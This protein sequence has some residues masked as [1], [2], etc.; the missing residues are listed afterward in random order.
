MGNEAKQD[1]TNHVNFNDQE[2]EYIHFVNNPNEYVPSSPLKQ[3]RKLSES[4]LNP[5]NITS[6]IYPEYK[7]NLLDNLIDN[8]KLN[9][10][11]IKLFLLMILYLTGEGFVMIGISLIIPVIGENWK[12]TEF[13]KGF[14]GGSVFLG[15]TFGAISAG[16]ISDSKGRKISF[17]IGNIISLGGALIGIILNYSFKWLA[18]SNFFIGIGIGI[19]IPSVFSLCSEITPSKVRSLI[20][21]WIWTC[22]SIGEISGCFIARHYEMHNYMNNNWKL[23]LIFRSFNVI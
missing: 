3:L 12:L 6:N 19:S 18:F 20:I 8:S 4:I 14:V 15:F 17:V 22:F 16:Y 1:K 11:H 10:E 21:G 5:N 7:N 13:E 23:L 2:N 9:F